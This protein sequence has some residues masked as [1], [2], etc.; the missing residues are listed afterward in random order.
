MPNGGSGADGGGRHP[1]ASLAGASE[2]AV[3]GG[4]SFDHQT[5]VFVAGLHRSGTTALTRCLAAHPQVS[6]L[7]GT[8]VPEDEGQHLQDLYP[9]G[10]QL[11]GPGRFAAN[12]DAHLTEESALASAAAGAELWAAWAPYWQTD[13]PFLAE[14]SPPNLLMTR[15]LSALFPGAIHLAIL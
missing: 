4:A 13:R 14:K 10:E 2:P 3:G 11:G 9:T 7:T 5:L 6:G 8:G 1:G 12:V 15:F